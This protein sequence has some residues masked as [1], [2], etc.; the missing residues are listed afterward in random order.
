MAAD[1]EIVNILRMAKQMGAE[2]VW[3]GFCAE[4]RQGSEHQEARNARNHELELAF[5]DGSLI[6]T[7]APNMAPAKERGQPWSVAHETR[8]GC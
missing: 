7:R 6:L 4:A 8:N 2:R 3:N 5:D 1:T